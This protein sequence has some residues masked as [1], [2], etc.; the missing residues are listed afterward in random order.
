[1][2][3]G[4]D[5][6]VAGA[7]GARETLI[8][9]GQG[10]LRGQGCEQRAAVGQLQAGLDAQSCESERLPVKLV[11]DPKADRA[12]VVVQLMSAPSLGASDEYLGEI[13]RVHEQGFVGVF[14]KEGGGHPVVGVSRV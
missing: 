3:R 6:E 14:A 13:E 12:Q 1:M 5:F 10:G 11:G 9:G 7:S 4:T 8:E 2:G